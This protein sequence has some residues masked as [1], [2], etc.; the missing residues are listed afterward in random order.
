MGRDSSMVMSAAQMARMSHLLEQ[1]LALDEAGRKRWLEALA[2]D[3]RDLE[4]ALRRA[5]LS[6]NRSGIEALATLPKIAAAA[7]EE[8][9]ES[10]LRPA[11]MVGPYRL[12]RQLGAGGMAEVWLAQRADGAYKRNLALKLPTALDLRAD[13][14]KRFARERDI[15][16]GLEH[17][18]IAR[19]YD[20]GISQEDLP[21][22]AMEYV[23]GEPITQ[24]CDT[25]LVEVRD[26]IKLFLQV[27]DA[28]QY[29]HARKVLHRDIKPSNILVTG[30][31]QVR[32]LDFGVAKLLADEETQTQ[33]TQLY[34]QAFTPEYASPEL[35]R[36]DRV[37]QASDIYSLGVVLYEL[38]SGTRPYRLK[39]KTPL[40]A[41]ERAVA[42]TQVPRP[43]SQITLEGAMA[44]A[45][46]VKK[47][48][49]Q[50]RGDLDA[51]ALKALQRDPADRYSSAEALADELQRHLSK[52]PIQA[53]LAH[54]LYLLSRFVLRHRSSI[55]ATAV[56]V[57]LLAAVLG[58]ALTRAA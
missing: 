27:L 40:V 54:P 41:L 28:V 36:G 9:V 39:A 37:Q 50:L 29:A 53:R 49:R 58:F 56:V 52:E 23:Q 7:G 44:R 18:N 25:H 21:Y 15:L 48:L 42:Q 10:R 26:R 2:Q 22:L 12:I 1:A 11:M 32:L 24:W 4:P 51:I 33:L 3:Q 5:L 55:T 34:G 20:A 57:A 30:S 45:T 43:S 6:Q 17:P 19:F 35:I 16:A 14:A 31:G 8:K 47:L 13:I 46:T 38:L